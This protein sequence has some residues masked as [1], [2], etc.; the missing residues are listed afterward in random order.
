MPTINI[1][2]TKTGQPG[3]QVPGA[4]IPAGWTAMNPSATSPAREAYTSSLASNPLI[5][6]YNAGGGKDLTTGE[7]GT[8]IGSK[9]DYLSSYRDYLSKYTGSLNEDPAV[10]QATTDLNNIQNLQDTRSLDAR[11]QYEDIIHQS[12]M[13]KGGAQEAG[14][15]ANRNASYEMANLGVAESSAAR[16]LSALTGQQTAK[17]DYYK[18]LLDSSQ[19]IKVGDQY[20]DP[21]TGQV[22]PQTPDAPKER[23]GIIGEYEYAK[24]QGYTGTFEKYQNED[25][26]RKRAAAPR[27]TEADKKAVLTADI[28]A[29]VSQLGQ[30]VKAKGFRGV[31]PDDYN[32]MRQ[33]LQDQYGYE[34]V[35]ELDSAMATLGL[36]VDTNW[37]AEDAKIKK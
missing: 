12:G 28:N 13:L 10:T 14:S 20:I 3:Y 24:Q 18:T 21:T 31:N 4:P 30:I 11:K 5:N 36:T 8:A 16:K 7:I 15:V 2:N 33:Y 34:G 17:Q 19:P 37:K 6:A 22:I 35:K 23:T 27:Q 9:Q 1:I 25:A 29:A 32:T 26:N